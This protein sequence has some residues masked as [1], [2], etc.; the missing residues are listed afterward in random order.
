MEFTSLER[1]TT[2]LLE[3]GKPLVRN[4]TFDS[5]SY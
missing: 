5:E 3:P 4:S 2:D 1:L